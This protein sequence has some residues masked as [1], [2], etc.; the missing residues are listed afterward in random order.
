MIFPTKELEEYFKDLKPIEGI[1][2][3]WGDFGVGKT[4]FALQTALNTAKKGDKI[5]YLYSKP[6]FPS[7]K[8]QMF[9]SDLTEPEKEEILDNITFIQSTSLN[10]LNTIIFNLEFLILS[11]LEQKDEMLQLIIIDSLTDLYRIELYQE[12]REKN[13]NLNY[14]LSQILA[15]LFYINETYYIEVLITNELTKKTEELEIL[16]VPSGGNV[17][18]Y[19]TQYSLKIERTEELNQ[20][21]IIMVKSGK[22]EL[23]ESIVNLTEFG[24][25]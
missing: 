4:T 23:S 12:K 15:N 3:V 11:N 1:V 5:V 25:K 9:L 21:K 20:R 24:F 16:E 19:W 22:E 17:M 8:V 14:Q 2:S 13:V 6:H 7:E 18:E 10:D